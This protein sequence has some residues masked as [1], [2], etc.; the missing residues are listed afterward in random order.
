MRISKEGLAQEVEVQRPGLGLF[1]RN[2]INK[3]GK[4]V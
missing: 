2:V 1:W 4:R 3:G